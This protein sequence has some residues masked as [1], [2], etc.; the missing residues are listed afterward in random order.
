MMTDVRN[1]KTVL[2]NEYLTRRRA[3]PDEIRTRTD[4]AICRALIASASFRFAS[5]VLAYAPTTY[6]VNIMPAVH[7]ALRRGKRVAFPLCE[8]Q[9]VMTFR[10]AAPSDLAKGMYGISAPQADAPLCTEMQGALCLVP[11][12]LF[13]R[14]GFRIGYGGGYYD[15]FLSTFEGMSLGI[16][17][18]DFILPTVPRGR[19]DRAV[20]AL[21]S[22]KGVHPI[23]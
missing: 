14:N 22:E 9:A 15:R 12:V 6:E 21:V 3:I 17:R 4:D 16:I 18:R 19:Y 13:D 7:E 10:Y 11:A 5:T 23:K 8:A 1:K 20:Q 2:R